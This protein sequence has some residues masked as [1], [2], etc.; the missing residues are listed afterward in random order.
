MPVNDLT[1]NQA[2][3]VLAAALSQAQGG[4]AVS[5]PINTSDFV[6]VQQ[7]ALKVGYDALNTAISQVLARTIFSARPYNRK[8]RILEAD[9]LTW[10]AHVR[11]VNYLDGALEDDPAY[12]LT[13]GQAVD[14][15]EVK[16]P[17]VVQTN[18]YGFNTFDYH[19]TIY[20]KQLQPALRGPEE[21]AGFLGG[22]MTHIQ[23]LMEKTHEESARMTVAN[24]IGSV[25]QLNAPGS[26]IHLIT[27]YN[28]FSGESV[29]PATVFNPDVF[30]GFAK[31]L[32]GRLKTLS[33]MMSERVT[34]MF[35]ANPAAGKI[36]RQT[37]VED[38]RLIVLADN[39]NQVD[40]NVL[41]TIFND[42]YLRTIPREELTYWQNI[43]LPR[44][45]NVTAGYMDTTTGE[46]T[47]AA[48]S[49][50]NVFGILY[51]RDAMGYTMFGESYDVTPYN[52]RGK[53]WN[54]F[55]SFQDRYWNDTTENAVIMLLD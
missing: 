7:T 43:Q 54:H 11:K 41:S 13:D 34:D 10:G 53:Y 20:K 3:E 47:S 19:Q 44:E 37:A 17:K 39:F 5:T 55:W 29:T 27:E 21:W 35:H 8:L 40:A 52:V 38:Q 4:V 49:L 31:W 48:V 15:Y 1:V 18:F 26:V 6:T 30:P 9:S 46:A 36:P 25:N 12:S 32:F 33:Q 16:K 22:L 23:N 42:Q 51:D 14:M 50:S 24:M 45:I 2:A 28:A